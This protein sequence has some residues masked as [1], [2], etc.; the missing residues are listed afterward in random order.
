MASMDYCKFENTSHDLFR[1][2]NALKRGE[3]ISEEE[4]VYA[5]RMR[6]YCEEYCEAFDEYEPKEE[7]EDEE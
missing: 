4:M 3:H 5:K 2:L 1:C 6:G 7:E